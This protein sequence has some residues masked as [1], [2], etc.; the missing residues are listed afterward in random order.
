[1]DEPI[2]QQDEDRLEKARQ[3]IQA[4]ITAALPDYYAKVTD[5]VLKALPDPDEADRLA[6]ELHRLEAH[7]DFEYVRTMATPR[8]YSV[9]RPDIDEGWELNTWAATDGVSR[10]ELVETWHW[11]RPITYKQ[12]Q[13]YQDAEAARVVAKNFNHGIQMLTPWLTEA[14]DTVDRERP[15]FKMGLSADQLW[16]KIISNALGGPELPTRLGPGFVRTLISTLSLA[17]DEV[18]RHPEKRHDPVYEEL[19]GLVEYLFLADS[20]IKKR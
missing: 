7:P 16:Y 10:D 3:D 11:L 19:H 15:H 17:A 8:V 9:K 13:E 14:G 6:H 4:A 18:V 1:M 12:A 5:A 2:C 20:E